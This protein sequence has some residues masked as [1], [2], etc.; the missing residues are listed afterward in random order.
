[1]S[2][3]DILLDVRV[4]FSTVMEKDTIESKATAV[5]SQNG[6]GK[7]DILPDHINFVTLIF[8]DITIYNKNKEDLSYKFKRGVLEVRKNKVDIFLGL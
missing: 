8:D 1:M 4:F 6:I 2:E 3:K 5:S 7:F